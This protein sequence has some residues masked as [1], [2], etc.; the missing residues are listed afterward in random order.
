M[1]PEVAKGFWVLP[2]LQSQPVLGLSVKQCLCFVPERVF[3]EAFSPLE[4]PS[5]LLK[6]IQSS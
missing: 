1:L 2:A 5:V 4:G 3:P 6:G